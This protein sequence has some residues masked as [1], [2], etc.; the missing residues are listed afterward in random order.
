MSVGI[1]PTAVVAEGAQLGADVDVG[2]YA[3]VGEHVEV[4]DGSRIGAHAVVDG[5]TRLGPRTRIFPHAAVG[6]I[7]QDLKYDGEPTR[8]ELGAENTIREFATLHIGTEGGGG[9]TRLGDRNLVMAYAHVAHDCLVGSGN[10]LANGA[11]L[12]GHVI[13]EDD[14]ILYGLRAA[15]PESLLMAAE[16][17]RGLDEMK[18]RLRAGF[19]EWL[20]GDGG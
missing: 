16:P 1:H 10:V 8:L 14:T 15:Q 18:V 19:E 9:I 20:Q 11:T 17:G 4:G 5:H 6:F 12:A 13:V 3:I 7:P 2:P